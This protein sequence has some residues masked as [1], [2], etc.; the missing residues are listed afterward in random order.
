[1]VTGERQT[2]LAALPAEIPCLIARRVH[3]SKLVGRVGI[4]VASAEEMVSVTVLPVAPLATVL[5]VVERAIE[6]AVVERAIEPAVVERAIAVA[7][8]VAIASGTGVCRVAPV[9]ATAAHSE[10]EVEVSA[11]AA[12]GLVATEDLP[13]L[14]ARE[15]VVAV[16]AEGAEAAVAEDNRAIYGESI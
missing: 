1:M 11:A 2:N 9:V 13:A 3:G 7:F 15:A 5:A 12:P 10:A 6:S 16:A 8:Q 14:E 4:S